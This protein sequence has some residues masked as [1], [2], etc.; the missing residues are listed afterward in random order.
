MKFIFTMLS[1]M[2]VFANNYAQLPQIQFK[3]ITSADGLADDDI[4]LE[5]YQDKQGFI[6]FATHGGLSKYDGY[7]FINYKHNF[8]DSTS[9]PSNMVNTIY[10]DTNGLLWIGSANLCSFNPATEHFHTFQHNPD[11]ST[12]IT[13]GIVY[14]IVPDGKKGLWIATGNGLEYLDFKTKVFTHYKHDPANSLSLSSNVIRRL[15]IDKRNTLWVGT[16]AISK[17]DDNSGGLNRF[18]PENKTFKRYFQSPDIDCSLAD[19]N[20]HMINED[21]NGTLYVGT[22]KAMLHRYNSERDCFERLSS[23]SRQL[24]Y[25]PHGEGFA[26]IRAMVGGVVQDREGVFWVSSLSG[27]LNR[28]DLKNDIMQHYPNDQ[29]T[30]MQL[31]SKNVIHVYEDRQGIMWL[32]AF[33][34]GIFKVIPSRKRFHPL[35]NNVELQNLLKNKDIRVLFEDSKGTFWIGTSE[36]IFRFYPTTGKIMN[37]SDAF[38]FD[39]R[40]IDTFYE[41]KD[42]G[43]WFSGAGVALNRIDLKS[44]NVKRYLPD[45]N[46]E[47]SLPSWQ[48]SHICAEND[49]S[50][51]LAGEYNG[52]VHFN[53]HFETIKNYRHDP[54]NERSLSDNRI[55]YT[56]LDQNQDLWIGTS[57]G[58][59]RLNRISDD[60]DRFL[61]DTEIHIVLEDINN[62]LWLG[63][64]GKG[65]IRFDRETGQS[66]YFNTDDGLLSNDILALTEDDQGYIW[67]GSAAGLNRLDP[68]SMSIISFQKKDGLLSQLTVWA[69]AVLKTKDGQLLFGGNNGITAFSPEDIKINQFPP[70]V[71]ITDLYI[72]DKPFKE[73]GSLDSVITL[74]YDQN[75]LTFKYVS[76][77]FKNPSHNKYM[78]KL[79]PYEKEWSRAGTLRQSRYTNLAP[80]EYIFH[81]RASNSDGVWNEKGAS[82]HIT[83]N[84]PWWQTA[85]AYVFVALM[86]AG[87]LIGI[88]HIELNRRKQ[89]E[90]KRMLEAENRRKTEELEEAR[91]LQLSMLPKE[92][93]SI[94]NLDI[95]VYMKTA[96]EVGGDYYDFSMKDDGSL[97]IAIGD[98]T[99]HGM[100]AGTMV[101]SMKSIF[102]TNASKMDIEQFFVTA[103]SGVK[104]MG[105]KR[106]MMGFSMLNIDKN[107]L[108]LINAGMPP[109][110][111]FHKK[112]NVVEELNEHVMPIGA[113]NHS[114]YTITSR[115][116]EIG[117]V[118]LML[119]DGMPEL[120]NDKHEMYG[121]DRI[122]DLLGKV[123]GYNSEEIIM[124]LREEASA[125]INDQDP[126]DDVTF[127]VIKVK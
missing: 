44:G 81:V 34:N 63:T 77:H 71:S 37:Y 59:N 8:Q 13:D 74:N 23:Q 96:T 36:D 52:L 110:F 42:D 38:N 6:W 116:L 54:A 68:Q 85:Y 25:A 28:F 19:N 124:Q 65:L 64:I 98:A 40:F 94:P 93:P 113:M 125:W 22:G 121:Y 5:I 100:K 119:T 105:L 127:V 26:Q 99:G 46:D 9:L 21:K 2:M 108:K 114:R 79:E 24:P 45:E 14:D 43:L 70:Y 17:W 106:M 60:F 15:Y 102:T 89:K 75:D 92:I 20:I 4:I 126:D 78:T 50:L 56:F 32:S 41:D 111:L 109:I 90:N 123:N 53:M 55:W 30:G 10:E 95:A 80:G 57:N 82:I 83:I 48:Y 117:D 104:S 91:Q 103:N 118:L 18:D 7:S 115:S 62:H 122:K 67:I 73:K 27:G 16:G 69:D 72:F 97:N 58:L 39:I 120:H 101:S 76:L 86:F 11:D 112:S 29:E 61:P 84:P 47:G 51:W 12:S 3:N 33:K 88:R 66:E 31:R 1:F 35:S 49:S 107:N 87:T